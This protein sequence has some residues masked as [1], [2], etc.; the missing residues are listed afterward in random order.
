M[1]NKE[2]LERR[3]ITPPC[4]AGDE[5][6]LRTPSFSTLQSSFPVRISL[7][8]KASHCTLPT[9]TPV[10]EDKV[11]VV[12]SPCFHE[13]FFQYSRPLLASTAQSPSPEPAKTVSPETT[14]PSF[15]AGTPITSSCFSQISCPAD[16][17]TAYKCPSTSCA[18]TSP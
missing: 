11:A 14:R 18:K 7:P 9:S 2:L 10:P 16:A 1:T 5:A 12:P 4:M 15:N 17:S 8:Y 6:R 3:Y 13:V